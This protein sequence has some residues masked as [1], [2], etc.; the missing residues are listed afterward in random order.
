MSLRRKVGTSANRVINFANRIIPKTQLIAIHTYPDIEDQVVALLRTSAAEESRPYR[1]VLL[2]ASPHDARRKLEVLVGANLDGVKVVR[3]TSVAGVWAYLRARGVLFTHGLFG[4]PTPPPNQVVINLWHGMPLK[5]IWSGVPGD[6]V[7]GCSYLL[8]T[9]DLFAGKLSELT[10]LPIARTPVTGLPRN[11][12]FFSTRPAVQA[13]GALAR[14]DVQR[15]LFFM[16]TYRRSTSGFR[17][18][19]G[20]EE[21]SP[22]LM[23]DAEMEQFKQALR[24]TGTRVLV[25]PHPLSPHYGRIDLSDDNIWIITD[26]WLHEHGVMLYEALGAVDGLIS[27]VSSVVVDHL[28]TRKPCIIYFPDYELYG[29]TRQFMLEPLEDYLPGPVCSTVAELCED[30]RRVAISA[31]ARRARSAELASRLN[32]QSAPSASSAVL[33]LIGAEL[34]TRNN[35][36]QPQPLP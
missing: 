4:S 36:V 23:T 24:E 29:K 27:D 14:R 3:K 18:E 28:C 20:S 33:D 22:L 19:D 17:S 34:N 15:V 2:V 6:Q 12:L 5:R 30:I 16:P 8:C 32:P 11:D 10:K 7:P 9:S 25:K 1:V 31:D 13:F 35:S 21:H 26:G